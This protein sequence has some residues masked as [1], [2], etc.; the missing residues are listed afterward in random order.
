VE[1]V[2]VEDSHVDQYFQ[3]LFT[4]TLAFGATRWINALI[5]YGEWLQCVFTTALIADEGGIYILIS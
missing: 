2:E 1:H 5:R 3:S 4:S